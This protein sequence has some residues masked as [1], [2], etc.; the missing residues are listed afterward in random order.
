MIHR[1]VGIRVRDAR[2]FTLLELVIVVAVIGVLATPTINGF[3]RLVRIARGV[4]GEAALVESKQLQDL[5][6][7][8]FGAYA[9]TLG[10]L[11]YD[12]TDELSYYDVS[13]NPGAAGAQLAYEA[14]A[15]PLPGFDLRT[16]SLTQNRDNSWAL[17]HSE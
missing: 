3:Q 7:L 10:I 15:A 1:R 11:G 4:E 6:R 14:T 16:W 12:R 13:M 8:D 9:Q 5:F 17:V 2:G